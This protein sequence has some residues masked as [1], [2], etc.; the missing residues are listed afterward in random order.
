MQKKQCSGE[1]CRKHTCSSRPRLN[2]KTRMLISTLLDSRDTAGVER[3]RSVPSLPTPSHPHHHRVDC[4][5]GIESVRPSNRCLSAC[6]E[7]V[8]SGQTSLAL[9]ISPGLPCQGETLL[10]FSA[11]NMRYDSVWASPS[12]CRGTA[13]ISSLKKVHHGVVLTLVEAMR[14]MDRR[15][16]MRLGI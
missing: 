3:H 5:I 7:E 6:K 16:G 9:R 4:C 10:L 15:R 12:T 13:R 14:H 1:M 11:K 2:N 8:Q